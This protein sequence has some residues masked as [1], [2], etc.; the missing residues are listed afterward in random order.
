MGRCLRVR[1]ASHLPTD[2]A[3]AFG[4]R[5]ASSFRAFESGPWIDL[6]MEEKPLSLSIL[7]SITSHRLC[8]QRC[9]LELF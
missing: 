4:T 2:L 7:T 3:S 8:Y 6:V 5:T 1:H 9:S